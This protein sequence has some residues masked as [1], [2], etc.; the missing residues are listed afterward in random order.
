MNKACKKCKILTDKKKCPICGST[1]LSKKFSGSVIII[2]PEESEMA[3]KIEATI[4][5]KYVVRVK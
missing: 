3:E 4:K 2:D 1:E 5:G